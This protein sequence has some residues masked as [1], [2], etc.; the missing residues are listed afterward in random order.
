LSFLGN[1][2]IQDAVVCLALALD[3]NYS[4]IGEINEKYEDMF[5]AALRAGVFSENGCSSIS[6]RCE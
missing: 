5:C 4:K 3:Y 1:Y 6:F 2:V